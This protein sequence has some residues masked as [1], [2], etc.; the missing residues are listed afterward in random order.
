MTKNSNEKSLT[1]AFLNLSVS[2][3]L[4]KSFVERTFNTAGV[5]FKNATLLR[6]DSA[7][8]NELRSR[9]PKTG[10]EYPKPKDGS[11]NQTS[12]LSDWTVRQLLNYCDPRTAPLP[13][14]GRTGR[15]FFTDLFAAYDVGPEA[16]SS[17]DMEAVLSMLADKFNKEK[18]GKSKI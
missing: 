7:L 12:S 18:S 10:N 1:E 2:K 16:S 14:L 11:L 5:T 13:W 3:V 4:S 6:C 9:D 15:A 17:E 8:R